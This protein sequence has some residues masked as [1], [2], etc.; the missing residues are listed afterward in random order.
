MKNSLLVLCNLQ[1]KEVCAQSS[2]GAVDDVLHI[3]LRRQ[4][5]TFESGSNIEGERVSSWVNPNPN[6]SGAN[7]CPHSQPVLTGALIP[8]HNSHTADLHGTTVHKC[9]F[10]RTVVHSFR[11]QPF[12]P[13]NNNHMKSSV[14]CLVGHGKQSKPTQ[15][16]KC[17]NMSMN[18]RVLFHPQQRAWFSFEFHSLG[19]LLTQLSPQGDRILWWHTL[20]PILS[21]H[22]VHVPRLG[23]VLFSVR[24]EPIVRTAHTAQT[25][26]R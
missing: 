22:A 19:S 26:A 4:F 13:T 16:P 25:V 9:N 1:P 15:F 20:R 14:D 12:M 11:E 24:S 3:S 23:L 10:Y 18:T 17:R 7:R 21:L 8:I 5:P 6:M 2:T